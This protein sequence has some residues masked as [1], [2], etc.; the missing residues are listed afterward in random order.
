MEW[1]KMKNLE[2]VD[3]IKGK[4]VAK[5]QKMEYQEPTVKN[6]RGVKVSLVIGFAS[7]LFVSCSPMVVAT[8]TPIYTETPV[9]TATTE[10]DG[11]CNTNS[12]GWDRY[13]KVTQ[14]TCE[15]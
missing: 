7:L 9:A 12:Q 14:N 5:Y 2:K 1:M 8:P 13:G 15:Y 3:V 10:A 6:D 4:T 11:N